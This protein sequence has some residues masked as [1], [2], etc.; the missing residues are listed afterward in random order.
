MFR[1]SFCGAVVPAGVPARLVVIQ[2]RSA[3]YP[4]RP[5]ANQVKRLVGGKRKVTFVD[6][7]GGAGCEIV[8][9]A[10]ACPKC[11]RDTPS[12]E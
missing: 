11:A 7:P 6:D 1:C 8:R 9:E 5:K 10:R 3:R 2:S 12:R 4:Y